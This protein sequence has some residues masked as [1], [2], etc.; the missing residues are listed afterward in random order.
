MS[1]DQDNEALIKTRITRVVRERTGLH[2][3]L[4]APIADEVFDGLCQTF[5]GERVYFVRSKAAR[6]A[7]VRAEFD[8]HNFAAVMRRHNISRATLYRIIGRRSAG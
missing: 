3:R 4:A 6:D 7:A 2:E 5:G 1:V 8:G